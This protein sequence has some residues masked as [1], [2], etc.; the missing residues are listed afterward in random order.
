MKL[1]FAL[2]LA[3][4][5]LQSYQITEMNVE[6]RV[7]LFRDVF[8]NGLPEYGQE[9]MIPFSQQEDQIMYLCVAYDESYYE[10]ICWA[11]YWYEVI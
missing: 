5:P 6:P 10:L 1:L 2:L 7:L 4:T 8:S 3:I 9:I 11:T